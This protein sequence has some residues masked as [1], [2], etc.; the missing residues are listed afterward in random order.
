M[1]SII[2]AIFSFPL[3]VIVTPFSLCVGLI[4]LTFFFQT[5]QLK[6][7]KKF[8]LLHHFNFFLLLLFLVV[9]LSFGS[10]VPYEENLEI[11]MLAIGSLCLLLSA[12]LYPLYS[13]IVFE[14]EITH[15]EM[16][17]RSRNKQLFN[18]SGFSEFKILSAG[19]THEVNNALNILNAKIEQLLRGHTKNLDKDLRLLLT[20]TNRIV[21]SMRGL[22]EFI[23][24]TEVDEKI[25]LSSLIDNVLELYGQRLYNHGIE[26]KTSG[27]ENK[28]IKGRRI[29]L[30]QVFLSLIN[31]S[32]ENLEK[33]EDKWI[34]IT[35]KTEENDYRI[36]FQDGSSSMAESMTKLLSDPYFTDE[37][38]KNN[39]IRLILTKDILEKHGGTLRCPYGY[40]NSTFVMTFPKD[41]SGLTET[42]SLD[43]ILLENKDLH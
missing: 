3:S 16:V 21:K 15:L 36:I 41:E 8:S 9:Q 34:S 39:G 18:Y 42:M 6:R 19:V 25:E 12:S 35:G 43:Q 13:E 11:G 40:E 10:W 32:I 7:L 30:E 31:N 27:L 5:Y 1:L 4:G 17:I 20:S 23:Y 22:R 14:R 2:L 38:L 29:P 33:C 28:Y 26:V 37:K 24:P